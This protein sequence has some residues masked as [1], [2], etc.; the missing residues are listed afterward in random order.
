MLQNRQPKTR[1][2]ACL[3]LQHTSADPFDLSNPAKMTELL[4]IASKIE[5]AVTAYKY[6]K[7]FADRQEWKKMFEREQVSAHLHGVSIATFEIE[8]C[9]S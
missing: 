4:R 9:H 1:Q 8:K 5:A 2:L 3:R 6:V 7:D